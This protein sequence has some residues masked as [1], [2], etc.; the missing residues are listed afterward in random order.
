MKITFFNANPPYTTVHPDAFKKAIGKKVP[1]RNT[2]TGEVGE[3]TLLDVEI[4]DGGIMVTYE[5]DM[6]LGISIN[7]PM[8]V[9]SDG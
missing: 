5:T 7:V 1:V 2:Y 4:V 6:N 9:V 8:E 3:G